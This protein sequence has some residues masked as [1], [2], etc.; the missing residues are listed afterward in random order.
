M[1][2]W[3]QRHPLAKGLCLFNLAPLWGIFRSCFIYP[4]YCEQLSLW[5]NAIPKQLFNGCWASCGMQV[6]EFILS[7]PSA[8]VFKSVPS[9]RYDSSETSLLLLQCLHMAVIISSGFVAGCCH[10]GLRIWD[11]CNVSSASHPA[12]FDQKRKQT[13]KQTNKQT[14]AGD[15]AQCY[16]VCLA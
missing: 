3:E 8:W 6:P 9:F 12:A 10:A 15:V 1:G 13:N 16:C 2:T 11:F 7:I 4:T 5:L 14:Q